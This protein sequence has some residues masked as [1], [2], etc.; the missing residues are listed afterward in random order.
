MESCP[1]QAQTNNA[2]TAP[3]PLLFVAAE[4]PFPALLYQ[5]PPATRYDI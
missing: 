3:A 5:Q 2:N 1:E 4:G